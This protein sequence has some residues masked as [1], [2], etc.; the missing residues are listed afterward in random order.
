MRTYS[1]A[2]AKRAVSAVMHLGAGHTGA[3]ETESR[4]ERETFDIETTRHTTAL[5]IL[6]GFAGMIVALAMLTE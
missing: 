6:I 3:T 5:V 1:L 2:A 4:F